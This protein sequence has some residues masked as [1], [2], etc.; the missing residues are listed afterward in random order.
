MMDELQLENQAQT[1]EATLPEQALPTP[2]GTEE[3]EAVLERIVVDL[4]EQGEHD[5]HAWYIA[6]KGTA[7]WAVR[8]I[9][10]IRAEMKENER[11]CKAEVAP[12]EAEIGRLQGW[13]SRENGTLERVATFFA[14]HLERF[15]RT[16][17]QNDPKAPKTIKLP[18]GSIALRAQQPEVEYDDEAVLAWA[19]GLLTAPTE[20]VAE[21]R[22]RMH[23]M[24]D[25]VMDALAEAEWN[26]VSST[27]VV[28]QLQSKV[29]ESLPGAAADQ[30]LI[31]IKEE[32]N[33]KALR[34]RF[35]L[36]PASEVPDGQLVAIDQESGEQIPGITATNRPAAFSVKTDE[37]V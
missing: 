8:R 4:S 17:H 20:H 14:A 15:M 6:D 33:K 25:D 7:A 16:L 2:D 34:Q 3:T 10:K 32:L 5:G 35:E 24:L 13:L 36:K 19:K 28:A 11:I 27:A 12:L 29:L 31:R 23:S 26:E 1:H 18:H 37:E 22:L 9:A 30:Q 21:L